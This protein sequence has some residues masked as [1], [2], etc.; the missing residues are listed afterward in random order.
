MKKRTL[1]RTGLLVSEIGHGLWGMGDWAG[2]DD[3]ASVEALKLSYARGCTFYDSA[4]AYGNGR[5]D[6]LLGQFI[7][8]SGATSVVAAGKIPPKNWKWPGSSSDSLE[9]VYPIDHVLEY[10][11]K[12]CSLAGIQGFDLMQLHVWDDSWAKSAAFERLVHELKARS[13][14]KFFGLS[15]NR[16]EPT[17]GT[18]AI[19]TGLVDTVQVIYNIFDQAPEDELFPLCAEHNVGVIARVPLDEGSLGG[20]FTADTKFLPEDWRSKY[21]GPE[22]LPETVERVGKLKAVLAREEPLPRIALR[23]ILQNP[24][25]STV[26]VGMRSAAHIEENV[27][28]SQSGSLAPATMVELRRHRWDRKVTPWAN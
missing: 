20:K 8:S 16:W 15:L 11:E 27:A 14:C 6:Q 23:F 7:R 26:I 21:F 5:S 2:A 25:V 1:G 24:V 13:L 9:D 28:V 22:N 18:K 12:S 3:R 17:N 10:A 4:F 19:K